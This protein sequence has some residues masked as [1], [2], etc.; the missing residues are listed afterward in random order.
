MKDFINA[1][2]TI[3]N[4][5]NRVQAFVPY[6]QSFLYKL[7]P[8]T[9][10][11]FP[12]NTQASLYYTKQTQNG[13]ASDVCGENDVRIITGTFNGINFVESSTYMY[14]G[15][16]IVGE[17]PYE[18][19]EI[20]GFKAGNRICLHFVNPTITSK[21][22][23]PNGVIC[24]TLDTRTEQGYNEYTKDA[25]EDDGSLIY[26]AN[27]DNL[28]KWVSIDWGDGFVTYNI[29]CSRAILGE[30]N[31]QPVPQ[32]LIPFDLQDWF[33]GFNF[34][35]AVNGQSS[36]DMDAFLNGLDFSE[37]D[38][39]VLL[40]SDRGSLMA[41]NYSEQ[42]AKLLIF[43]DAGTHALYSTAD[44]ELNPPQ[45][46]A[47]VVDKGWNN[48]VDGKYNTIQLVGPVAVIND[49]TPS[50]WNG[51]LVGKIA[52]EPPTPTGLTPFELNQSVSG[53][54]IDPT[55]TP[56]G[57]ASMAA[58]VSALPTPGEGTEHEGSESLMG[59]GNNGEVV[60]SYVDRITTGVPSWGV[61]ALMIYS[62]NFIVYYAPQEI[63]VEDGGEVVA[64]IPAGWSQMNMS[65]GEME[66]FTTQTTF[67]FTTNT[68]EGIF[69]KFAPLNGTVLGSTGATPPTGLTPFSN[70]NLPYNIG[71]IRVDTG[72][73]TNA[74]MNTF[75][76]KFD[77]SQP[78]VF[79][80]KSDG[81][82]YVLIDP[83]IQGLM[84][85]PARPDTYAA[86]FYTES[87]V[88][89]MSIPAG[90]V[91]VTANN[92]YVSISGQVDLVFSD[93]IGY[94][95][96]NA[97]S[98]FQDINGIVVGTLPAQPAGLTPFDDSGSQVI[99]GV[100]VDPNANTTALDTMLANFTP[101]QTHENT[102]VEASDAVVRVEDSMGFNQLTVGAEASPIM[103][104]PQS[105]E[106]PPE[107]GGVTLEKGWYTIEGGEQIVPVT[108]QTTSS[109]LSSATVS[110]VSPLL[111]GI[112]GINIGAEI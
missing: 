18:T 94:V 105:V 85:M 82:P 80:G 97:W 34:G 45:E 43:L 86:I 81:E 22:S 48:L 17:I 112:N 65:T 91:G 6:A 87:G 49:T 51:V 53:I 23:L 64:T 69:S 83:D 77:M 21:D 63:I 107:M 70:Q 96:E 100:V 25:F 72:A 99:S 55:A 24:K 67:S 4:T 44:C 16:Y 73:L 93:T 42:N 5:T 3:A 103:Y 14:V 71:G 60:V 76:A 1:K 33:S 36:D 79:V 37:S 92:E 59:I 38:E 62:E 54:I 111:E 75:L 12:A 20:M 61:N 110:Y 28:K 88:P 40:G 7:A 89:A 13:I 30:Y 2:V 108:T 11:Q 46:E 74:Q 29:D 95:D 102:L 78:T 27:M 101:D 106:L 90:W 26:I 109:L 31:P 41:F 15:G 9:A 50:T 56:E 19:L 84:I 8:Q 47:I 32:E 68:V 58:Y 52:A 10:I 98:D 39:L 66:S 104:L 57:Y 35:D